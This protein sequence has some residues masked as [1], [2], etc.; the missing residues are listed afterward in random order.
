MSDTVKITLGNSGGKAHAVPTEFPEKLNDRW[1]NR[2]MEESICGIP[3]DELDIQAI[4]PGGIPDPCFRCAFL[5]VLLMNLHAERYPDHDGPMCEYPANQEAV[6][7]WERR[8][9]G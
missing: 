4:V 9:M 6:S 8:V 5:M 7:Q 1:K 2:W 3:I